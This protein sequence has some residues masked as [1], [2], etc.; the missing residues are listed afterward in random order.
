MHGLP[1]KGGVRECFTAR[2]GWLYSSEDYTGGELVTLAQ[3]CLDLVGH[4][5]LAR[6]LNGGLDAHL[7]LA[8]TMMG[9]DYAL[10][11]KLKKAGDKSASYGRQAA[12]GANFGYGGGMAEL[13]FTLRKRSDPTCSRRARTDLTSWMAFEA[14]AD[15]GRAS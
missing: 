11:Q 12:K 6:A 2:K 1:R 5:E 10:M 13:T 9:R 8:G 7:A 3:C 15:S 14:T 4:S